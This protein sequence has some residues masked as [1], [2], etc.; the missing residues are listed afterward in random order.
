MALDSYS[1]HMYDWK[2]KWV[3]G[4]DKPKGMDPDVWT[5]LKAYWALPETQAASQTN[6]KNRKK[7][8][9]GT[10]NS[11]ATRFRAREV[12]M[13]SLLVS[14]HFCKV[15]FLFIYCR[16]LKP[17]VC[18]WIII[19]YWRWLTTTKKPTRSTSRRLRNASRKWRR[20]RTSGSRSFLR[21]KMVRRLQIVWSC[22]EMSTTKLSS[23]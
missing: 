5:G 14:L 4:L 15:D 8:P 13:V 19:F 10:H 1:G 21:L 7:N 2:Q 18:I 23:R 17:V 11:G 9:R 6:S 22:L 20:G 3:N 16:Q 12:N